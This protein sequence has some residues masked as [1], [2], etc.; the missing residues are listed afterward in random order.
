M[1]YH[2]HI[3]GYIVASDEKSRAVYEQLESDSC[4]YSFIKE[5]MQ[6]ENYKFLIIHI[7]SAEGEKQLTENGF[8]LIEC[9]DNWNIYEL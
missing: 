1:V 7:P 4:D 5:S 3:F 2:L 6:S 9:V 8:K